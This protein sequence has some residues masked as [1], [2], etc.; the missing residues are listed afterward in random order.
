MFSNKKMLVGFRVV[1]TLFFIT[2]LFW[3]CSHRHKLAKIDPAFSQYIDAYTSGTVSKKSYIRIQLASEATTAHTLNEPINKELFSFS[4]SVAGKAYWIDARTIEFR[5]DKDLEKATLYEVSFKL[6][7]VIEVPSKYKNFIFNVQIIQPSF[8]IIQNGLRATDKTNM[9]LSGKIFTADIEESAAIEK[10]LSANLDAKALTISWQHNEANKTHEFFIQNIVRTQAAQSLQLSWDGAP[11]QSSIHDTKQI[12]VPAIGDYKVLNVQAVQDGEQ[13]VSVQ[14]SD[15]ISISQSLQGLIVLSNQEGLSFTILGSEVRVYAPAKIDGNITVSINEGIENQW[16]NKLPKGFS[17]NVFFENRL[18]S[19]KIA[20]KGVILPNSGGKIILPFDAVNL[21]AVDVSI[22]KIY[23]NNIPQF[24]QTSNLDGLNN[25]ELRRVAKP[26]VQATLKLDEDKGLNLH[27]TNRFSLSLD[28]YI[29]TEPGAIY[30]ITLAFRP[31]YSLYTC[32]ASNEKEESLSNA[33]REDYYQ[34]ESDKVDDDDEFWRRYNDSYPYGYNWEDRDNPCKKGYYNSQRFDGRNILSTNI[35]L[36]AKRGMD[37]KLFV[38]V[39][40]IISTDPMKDVELQ[41]L[42]YQQQIVGKGKSNSEGLAFIDIKHKPYLLI[43]K[44]GREKSYLKIDDGSSLPLAKFD[45]GGAEIKN[46]IKA[47]VFGERG[48]WRPGDTL[49]LGCIVEDKNNKLPKGHPIELELI[50]PRGQL[51]KKLVK[52][53]AVDG[54]NVFQVPTNAE[55][56]TGNWLCKVKIGGATFEKKVKIETVMPNRLKINLDF[57]GAKALGKNVTTTGLLSA[58]WLFG[59]KAQQLKARVDAQLYKTKTSFEHFG[60]YE[61]D[62]P[63]ANYNPQSKTIFDGT[64]SAEGTA[65]INPAFDA[66]TDAPGMLKANLLVKV[67]EPGGGFSID[68]ISMPFHPYSAYVGLNVPEAKDNWGYLQSNKQQSFDIVNVNTQGQLLSGNNTLEVTLYKIQWRWWWDNND[69]GLSNFTQ[70]NVNKLIKNE[71]LTTLNGKA[72]FNNFFGEND[73]GRYLLLV[74]D[75]RSGHVTGKTFY[76]DDDNWRSRGNNDDATAATMLSFTADKTK[77]NVGEKVNLTIPSGKAGRALISI[78]TGAKVLKTFWVNTTEGQTK[79]SFDAEKEMS[80]NVYINISL[81]Q[82]HSQTFNDLPIRMYGA[83]PIIVEDKNT[84]LKP[85][86]KIEESIRPLQNVNITIGEA[87]S[88]PMSYVIAIVD[89]GLLDLTHFKTPDPHEYFYAKEAL[90]VKSWDVYDQVIGVFGGQLDR[91]LTIGGDADAAAGK[92]RKANRFKPVVRFLGP[93]KSNGGSQVQHFSLPQYMGSV[94]VMVIAAANGAYGMAEKTVKVKSP[95]MMLATLP[96][97]LGPEET[98]KIPVTVFATEN[99]MRNVKLSV[100]SN[101]FIEVGANENIS[102]SKVGEQTVYINAK[103][104][105]AVGIGKV[106]LIASCGNEKA[107]YETELD[108]RNANSLITQVN[109]ATIMPGQSYQNTIAKIGMDKDSKATIEISSLPAINL[110]KRLGYLIQ[111]PHGCIEQ[112]TSAVFPQLVLSNMLELSD[113]KKKTIDRNIRAAIDKLQNFQQTDGGFSYWP[114]YEATSSD[115]WGTNYAGHFLLEASAKGYSVSSNMLV[116]W[117]TFQHNKAVAWNVTTAPYYGTD[118]NQAYRLFLL[119]L[120]KSPELGAMN[121]LKEYKF[122]TPEGK[123]QLAAA[124]YLIGQSQIALNLISGLPKT[125]PPRLTPGYTFGSNLRDEAMVLN[126]LTIMNRR[127]EAVELVKTVANQLAQE[128]WYS[129]QTTAYA[130]LAIAKYAGDNT[131]NTKIVV[132]GSISGKSININSASP[133]WQNNLQWDAPSAKLQFTNKGTNIIYISVINEGRP[134]TNNPTPIVNNPIIL[135]VNVNYFTTGG[136]ALDINNLKQGTDF[137]AKVVVKNPG[138][139]GMYSKM[140]LTQVFPSGWEILNTRLFNS[141]G[142]FKSSPTDY[143][144]IRDDRVFH[145][146]DIKQGETLTYYVQLN[147]AYIGRFFWPGVYCEAMYDHTI[148]GG[149]TGKWV[150]VVQ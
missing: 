65:S 92:T 56:P 150:E 16:G 2:C 118:L 44:N 25:Y 149:V 47:F 74:K 77:Y 69:E 145:Y 51:Y 14:F 134:V 64:L 7:A 38:A 112:T 61:F 63:T 29:Q 123:W 125:F 27:A 40:N 73:W 91:I 98:F 97:V 79:F 100:Q 55:A 22:I 36:T 71:T 121:R 111:Y 107:V 146:F 144:D 139:R 120:A 127:E 101:P 117:K 31:E 126:A 132:G 32:E 89:D 26:I 18:P 75:T 70:S 17:A 96:R 67:F 133:L 66:G 148:S 119:A 128:E 87:N 86:I 10:L 12:E 59:A 4:P 142:Q 57:G 46:G 104:K 113:D 58:N 143:M 60:N 28:K 114:G 131:A 19:V 84:V 15:A 45:I 85:I 42:D 103:V 23:E 78:E 83:I 124:Y 109:E 130:L 53:N 108:I 24:L 110:Q 105:N 72:T 33:D 82:P 94:R 95:L 34:N 102:F 140:A 76:I 138:Q 21:K 50:S 115:E 43:A 20:G 135:Q 122:L 106:K 3:S 93:F 48:V 11:L 88:K 35:G 62:N 137:V 8:Q 116:Q 68:N 80:P 90:G 5:P 41:V 52:T 1:A 81:I 30:R 6:G 39:N 147:A 37:D 13:Y 129:T 136:A 49:F 141:E 99:S 54:F 9:S